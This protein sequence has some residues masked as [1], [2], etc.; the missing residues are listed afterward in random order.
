MDAWLFLIVFSYNNGEKELL[1]LK[2]Q[3]ALFGIIHSLFYCYCL[4]LSF[5]ILLFLFL[6]PFKN[7]YSAKTQAGM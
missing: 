2:G 5:S 7:I 3:E 6:L 4:L 1:P